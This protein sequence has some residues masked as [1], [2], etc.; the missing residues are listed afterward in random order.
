MI[1][2]RPE[3]TNREFQ[4]RL[5]C[6]GLQLGVA[7]VLWLQFVA[8]LPVGHAERPRRVQGPSGDGLEH[9]IYKANIILCNA[10]VAA[11]G[12]AG[13]KATVGGPMGAVA[14]YLRIGKELG[15]VGP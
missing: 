14:Q 10:A 8:G 1:S 5:V 15:V 4:Q 9:T 6:P 11:A 2:A 12:S 7:W 13:F 3:S